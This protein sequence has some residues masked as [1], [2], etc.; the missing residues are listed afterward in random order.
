[1]KN[2]KLFLITIFMIFTGMLSVMAAETNEVILEGGWLG[3]ALTVIVLIIKFVGPLIKQYAEKHLQAQ[4]VDIV[5]GAIENIY[6]EVVRDLKKA[7]KDNKFD[8]SEKK[9]VSKLA[10]DLAIK[11]AK[12][13][14]KDLLIEKGSVWGSAL[15]SKLVKKAKSK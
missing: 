11:E 9:R 5:A 14:V 7:T 13:P 10:W 2:S 1:M 15:I 4:A 3:A 8:S 6:I 12:G